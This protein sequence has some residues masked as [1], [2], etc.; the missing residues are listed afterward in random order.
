MPWLPLLLRLR[1]R[2]LLLLRLRAL[3]PLRLRALRLLRLQAFPAL[4]LAPLPW[5]LARIHRAGAS[6]QRAPEHTQWRLL[7]ERD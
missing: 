2:A 1:R 6:I 4:R 3:P 7:R 5:E